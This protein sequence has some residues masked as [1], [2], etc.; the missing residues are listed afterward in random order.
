M[1]NTKSLLFVDDQQPEVLKGQPVSKKPVRSDHNINIAGFEISNDFLGLRIRQEPTEHFDSNGITSESFTKRLQML[2][3]KECR[4][5]QHCCLFAVL[6][7]L[8]DGSHCDFS[9]SETNIAANESIHRRIAF[10]IRLHFRDR[11]LL[12]GSGFVGEG[13]FE[14]VLPW[15]IGSKRVTGSVNSLLVQNH[16]FLGNL[17]DRFTH[18]RFVLLPFATA[19]ATQTGRITTSEGPNS[20]DL[21]TR[22]IKTVITSI[23]KK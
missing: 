1:R 4:R 17:R 2:L 7:G 11:N 3:R 21:I 5:H 6:H 22:N 9:F 12:I 20:I 16:E 19:K 8:E 18:S 13:L 14:F 23:L 10:H 15:S